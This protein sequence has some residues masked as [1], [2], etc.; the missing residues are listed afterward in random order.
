LSVDEPTE[1]GEP[2]EPRDA[3]EPV[4]PTEPIEPHEIPGVPLTDSLDVLPTLRR[5]LAASFRALPR[6]LP[7]ILPIVVI[8]QAASILGAPAFALEPYR[9]AG[10]PA[11]V[12]SAADWL[13]V[14]GV[15]LFE[16]SIGSWAQCALL[17]S[18]EAALE[19]EPVPDFAHAY[20]RGLER[21]P[22]FLGTSLIVTVA[23]GAGFVLC[24]VPGV[25][26]LALL[27]FAVLRSVVRGEGV[28]TALRHSYLLARGRV[29]RLIGAFVVVGIV[30]VPFVLASSLVLMALAM[31]GHAPVDAVSSLPYIAVP[32][33]TTSLTAVLAPGM[34]L[35]MHAR[36]ESLGPKH[37]G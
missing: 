6:A 11:Q 2:T 29:W 14:A 31:S 9:A 28:R 21:V 1:P 19:G 27:S 8:T 16:L 23:F 7:I 22:A 12:V 17:V 37:A 18:I 36:L 26:A 35:A 25:W 3:V 34:Q 32:V 13:V 24:F 15:L 30:V 20:G 4:E 5:G 10:T 33:V